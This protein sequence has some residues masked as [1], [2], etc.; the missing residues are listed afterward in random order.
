[1]ADW[2]PKGIRETLLL[3]P[4]VHAN[5]LLREGFFGPVIRYHYDVNYLLSCNLL[6]SLAAM[7]LASFAARRAGTS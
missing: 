1:M 3:L 2:L 7:I 4:M 5:E 6:I